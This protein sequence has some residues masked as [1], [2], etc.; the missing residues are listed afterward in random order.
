MGRRKKERKKEIGIIS[1]E[2][3]NRKSSESRRKE[4][5]KIERETIESHFSSLH[6]PSIQ[7][8]VR[9]L[10]PSSSTVLES[11]STVLRTSPTVLPSFSLPSSSP[12]SSL[13]LPEEMSKMRENQRLR[14]EKGKNDDNNN[15]EDS[16]VNLA[17]IEG[18]GRRIVAIKEEN[19][20]KRKN[21]KNFVRKENE[22]ITQVEDGRKNE[23]PNDDNFIPSSSSTPFLCS[24]SSQFSS[25][26]SSSPAFSPSSSSSYDMTSSFYQKFLSPS[27]SSPS[28][29]SNR[30][31]SFPISSNSD[32]FPS[33]TP[34][35]S[36][37]SSS[38]SSFSIAPSSI[39]STTSSTSSSISYSSS[40]LRT[41]SGRIASRTNDEQ[42]NKLRERKN[43]IIEK[44]REVGEKEREIGE[45]EREIK[46]KEREIKEK[47]REIKEEKKGGADFL[48]KALSSSSRVNLPSNQKGIDEPFL[49]SRPDQ[50]QKETNSNLLTSF[51]ATKRTTTRVERTEQ[52]RTE[53]TGEKGKRE[54]KKSQ[55]EFLSNEKN[56]EKLEENKS[57]GKDSLDQND[58]YQHDITH[59]SS[60]TF[61]TDRT[62]IRTNRDKRLKKRSIE[63]ALSNCTNESPVQNDT[64][65]TNDQIRTKDN[66]LILMTLFQGKITKDNWDFFAWN[67]LFFLIN[68]I[69]FTSVSK[70][71]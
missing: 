19:Q 60:R 59:E 57:N 65:R 68:L 50:D 26:Q 21:Y 69:P 38:I 43:L 3:V 25:L 36:V 34:S 51:L 33:N 16:F 2:E 56:D 49:I 7:S 31:A 27:S 9:I 35:S 4:G 67:F 45:K 39:S 37:S 5:S 61:R 30:T 55:N 66:Q 1:K 20:R 18:E 46:E 48:R 29:S 52:N 42:R 44:E 41:Q 6:L 23:K 47:E 8:A 32:F 22:E 63:S 13:L 10:P 64:I 71:N 17:L 12:T 54:T 40:S 58:R 53:P 11:Y 15:P 24:S 70:S 62:H 28:H 14:K